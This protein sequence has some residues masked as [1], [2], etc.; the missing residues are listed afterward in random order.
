MNDALALDTVAG[1]L[2]GARRIV[3]FSGAGL[4]KASGIPTYR[5]AGGL[6]TQGNNLRFS[7]IGALRDDPEG[8]LAFWAA[9]RAELEKAEPNAAHRALAALDRRAADVQHITQNVD[10]LLARAGCGIVHEL[11]GSLA[12]WRCDACGGAPMS[13]RPHCPSCG[14]LLRPDVVMFGELLPMPTLAAAELAA[15]RSEVCLVVG[16][17]AIVHPA[18]GIV[19]KAQARGSKIVV[20]NVEPSEIDARA[21]AVL[22]GRAEEILPAL[23]A[24]VG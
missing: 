19:G 20:I 1:W 10:G 3:S 23:V 11:H 24:A 4:S 2:A 9:R 17:T 12:R 21:D 22:R 14:G 18:A 13:A 7:E 8:F 6:W 16:T 5:D 15:R